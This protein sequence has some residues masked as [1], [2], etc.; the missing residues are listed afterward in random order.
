MDS[1][2]TKLAILVTSSLSWS[3]RSASVS[4]DSSL[5]DGRRLGRQNRTCS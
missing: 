4:G 2:A 1:F 3:R 5:I